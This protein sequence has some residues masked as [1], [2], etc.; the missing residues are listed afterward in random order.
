MS[1]TYVGTLVIPKFQKCELKCPIEGVDRCFIYCEFG[2]SIDEKAKLDPN[3]PNSDEVTVIF[4][5]EFISVRTYS[6]ACTTYTSACAEGSGII[7]SD[8]FNQYKVS[9]METDYGG[10]RGGAILG[11]TTT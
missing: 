8:G 9:K 3:K 6:A 11:P 10:V 2:T 7:V 4:Y 1:G 5:P